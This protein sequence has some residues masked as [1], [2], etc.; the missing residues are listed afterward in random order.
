[1][2]LRMVAREG[3]SQLG[4]VTPREEVLEGIE[5]STESMAR[6]LAVLWSSWLGEALGIE[7]EEARKRMEGYWEA[8][9]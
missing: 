6:A 8:C 5:E 7:M 1:M 9:I 2:H 3:A 4:E